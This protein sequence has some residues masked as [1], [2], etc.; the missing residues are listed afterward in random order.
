MQITKTIELKEGTVHFEGQIEG[1][2]LDIVIEAGLMTLM[3]A[4]VIQTFVAK[5]GDEEEIVH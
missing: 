4:G 1:K 2:E 3:R 5:D